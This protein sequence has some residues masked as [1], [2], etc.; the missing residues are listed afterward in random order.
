MAANLN[1]PPSS[2]CLERELGREAE[3]RASSIHRSLRHLFQQTEH[4]IANN[5]FEQG[6]AYLDE[7][8]DAARGHFRANEDIAQQAGLNERTGGWPPHSDL[9][10]RARIL[11]A[12]CRNAQKGA[13]VSLIRN[14]LVVLL[15]DLV[16]CDI[17]F[18]NE[19]ES[20]LSGEGGQEA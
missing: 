17:R 13:S 6:A 9:L 5:A 11:Q 4:A 18:A 1:V 12:R 3:G 7:L 20:A 10:D 2:G 14:E 19:V 16:E 15:S 8:I